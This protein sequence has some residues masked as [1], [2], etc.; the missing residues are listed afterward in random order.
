MR[1]QIARVVLGASLL[2]ASAMA[3]APASSIRYFQQGG[4]SLGAPQRL[5]AA[6]QLD[7]EHAQPSLARPSIGER[8]LQDDQDY[9]VVALFREAHGEFMDRRE[10]YDPAVELRA[11]WMPTQNIK[12]E[13]GDFDLFGYD[14][15]AE[16]PVVIYPDSYLL[17][18]VY[19]YGRHYETSNGFGS[20]GNVRGWGDETLT[21]AGVRVGLGVF[22]SDNVLFEAVT[23]PGVY[24]DLEGTLTHKDY[25]FPSS[26]MFTVQANNDLFFKF[27]ARYNQIYQDA[28]WLPW[29]GFSWELAEGVRLD[30]LLPESIEFAWWATASTSFS[31]GAT[32]QG[33]Q[34]R[35]RSSAGTNKEQANVNVQEVLA[36]IGMTHRLT[37]TWSFSA[38]AGSVLAGHY[39]LSDG[40]NTFTRASGSLDQ[41]LY[42]DVSLGID[43]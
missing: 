2:I 14:I 16:F 24:S 23:N 30:L 35:V 12:R 1:N 8:L 36:Y 10:R 15:D 3:Q 18:G 41:G 19:Q 40:Q 33:A 43:W 26:A 39:D 17:L 38:R 29:L 7:A 20:Q 37:D 21:A 22:V 5:A 13:P 4:A 25:D 31:I 28:P 34:Y 6:P 42:A 9:S 11:R 27:G 32:V